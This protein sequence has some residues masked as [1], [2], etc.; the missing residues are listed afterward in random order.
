MH[1]FYMYGV[2]AIVSIRTCTCIHMEAK[3][4]HQMSSITLCFVPLGQGLTEPEVGISGVGEKVS[5]LQ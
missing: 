1:C 4:G 3:G 5:K 2:W